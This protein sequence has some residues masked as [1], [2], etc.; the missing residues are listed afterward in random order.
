MANAAKPLGDARFELREFA[1][2]LL[3]CLANR[4]RKHTVLVDETFRQMFHDRPLPGDEGIR[5]G[6]GKEKQ[7]EKKKKNKNKNKN[8]ES[9]RA[10]GGREEE[11]S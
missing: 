8:N 7:K 3:L 4:S 6:G 1:V 2:G 11:K 5:G 9:G 10:R